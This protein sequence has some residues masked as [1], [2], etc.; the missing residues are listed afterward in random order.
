MSIV[1]ADFE[2][3]QALRMDD[4]T[5]YVMKGLSKQRIGFIVSGPDVGKGYLCLSI[6]YELGSDLKLLNL[7]ANDRYIK[8]LYWPVE[9]GVSE[10]ATRMLGHLESFP[11]H[12]AKQIS[13][14]VSLWDS[15]DPLC[16]LR[17]GSE[18]PGS[19]E[20]R[21][22]LIEACKSFDLLIV[23]TIREAAGNAN[24]V[25]DDNL[26]K[27][28]LKEIATKAD[29]AILLVHHLT[30][31]VIKGQEKV[32]NVSGSGFSRT[33]ANSRMHLYL[34]KIDEKRGSGSNLRLSHIKANYI[35][36]E[37]RLNN[38]P[39]Q[40][41][42]NN[43][44]CAFQPKM[45]KE[46]S[47]SPTSVHAEETNFDIN[48]ADV[49]ANKRHIE[50]VEPV[51]INIGEKQLSQKSIDLQISKKKELELVSDDDR[52]KLRQFNERKKRDQK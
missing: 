28:I 6:A 4:D 17:N 35:K 19:D 23:D 31:A 49:L 29:V 26:V 20:H 9:D 51:T 46:P 32:S 16:A 27:N 5:H 13:E 34:E 15:S 24:E 3:L 12:I 2:H 47:Y 22:S 18:I 36:K 25:D 33:Q 48:L 37:D 10:V 8:T 21:N 45:S 41:T 42:E 40:W 1:K 11:E 44:L 7:K 43:L 52:E 50:E 39:L 38:L 14:N 30:K